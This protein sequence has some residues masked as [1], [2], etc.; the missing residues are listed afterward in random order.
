MAVELF[1]AR[2]FD[3]VTI[4]EI[5]EAAGIS[6]RTFFRYFE[7]KE[8]AVLPEEDELLDEFRRLLDRRPGSEPI[9]TT[10]R[11]ATTTLVAR[12]AIVGGPNAATRQRLVRDHP[13]IHAR[14]L[15]LRSR[16]ETAVRDVLA[17]HLGVDPATDLAVNIAAAT[18]VA[19]ARATIETWMG[20][21]CDDDLGA[22]L[23]EAFDLLADG[24]M[25]AGTT[26]VRPAQ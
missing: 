26:A 24:P 5:A 17:T 4:D 3:E 18:S 10:V 8:D 7:S 25:Q 12:A 14:A 20:R 15:E 1:D 6:R 19:T 21:G 9:M 23:D 13:S 2:G 22:L 11:R 16:W